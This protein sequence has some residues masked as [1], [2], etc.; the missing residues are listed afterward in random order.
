MG[1]FAR[2][3]HFGERTTFYVWHFVGID[4]NLDK[5]MSREIGKILKKK[6]LPSLQDRASEKEPATTRSETTQ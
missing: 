1:D 6:G 5:D 4:A 3:G 2:I